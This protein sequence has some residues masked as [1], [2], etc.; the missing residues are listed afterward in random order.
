M[1]FV[2]LILAALAAVAFAVVVVGV[3]TTDRRLRLRERSAHGWADGFARKVLG[4]YVRQHTGH[5]SEEDQSIDD[6]GRG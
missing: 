3:Q 4:V 2:A 1:I 5:G 6:R